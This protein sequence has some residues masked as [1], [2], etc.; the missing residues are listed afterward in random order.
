MKR[1]LISSLCVLAMVGCTKNSTDNSGEIVPIRLG[2]EFSAVTKAPVTSGPVNPGNAITAGIIGWENDAT[3]DYAK[4]AATWNTT[5]DVAEGPAAGQTVT[6]TDQKFYN[7]KETI[8][9]YMKAWYPVGTLKEKDVTFE[10]TLG[11]L[12]VM[13]A[14]AI[15]GNRTT[16]GPLTL[17]FKHL[18][19]QINF[20]VKRSAEVAAVTVKA[21]SLNSVSLPNGISLK[22]NTIACAAEGNLN[23]SGINDAVIGINNTTV[24]TPVMI[25]P[26][27]A[28]NITVTTSDTEYTGTVTLSNSQ[29]GNTMLAGDSY[30]VTVTI[31]A[32]GI[33]L[34]ATIEPWKQQTGEVELK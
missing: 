3:P 1:F 22:D 24:G 33:S 11:N 2:A 8:D 14:E 30:M 31:G 25:K 34:N 21:I 23:V 18:T 15:H 27:N 10:N 6:W 12:D 29:G 26:Q 13:A 9:T 16:A 5:I 32:T 7:V 28:L 20:Q 19:S 17:N 4:D